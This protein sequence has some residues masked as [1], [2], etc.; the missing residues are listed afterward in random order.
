MLATG[1]LAR[2][3][4]RVFGDEAT[5]AALKTNVKTVSFGKDL[6]PEQVGARAPR[7][8]GIGCFCR[9]TF[10]VL[11]VKEPC[12]DELPVFRSDANTGITDFHHQ[13][14]IV[15]PRGNFYPPF[16]GRVL[17]GVS[18]DSFEYLC[19]GAQVPHD[20]GFL[21]QPLRDLYFASS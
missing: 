14:H 15:L 18:Q 17:D 8:E 1:D 19:E 21:C 9:I 13:S 10:R 12:E 5:P 2:A 3:F 4:V 16:V 6:C 7:I 11:C 20:L